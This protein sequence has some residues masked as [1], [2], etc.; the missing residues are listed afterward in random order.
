[1]IVQAHQHDTLDDV[2]Y[3]YFGTQT[4]DILPEILALNPQIAGII[5]NEH[6]AVYLPDIAPKQQSETLKLWD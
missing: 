5:L 1:M 3:R 2:A 4:V 6:Q